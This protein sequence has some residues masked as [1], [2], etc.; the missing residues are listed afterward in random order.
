MRYVNPIA[1]KGGMLKI[2]TVGTF[3][4]FNPFSLKG[5]AAIGMGGLYKP[6]LI[7]ESL[8]TST[9]DD[10]L[11][12]YCYLAESVRHSIDNQWIIFNLRKDVFFHNGRLLTAK[13]VVFSF[14]FLKKKGSLFFKSHYRDIKKAVIL[15]E[16]CV[17]FLF[18]DAQNIHLAYI[19]GKLPVFCR[20]SD[21]Y[22]SS[23]K[24]K[25]NT[26]IGTGPYIVQKAQLGKY[27]TYRKNQN[28]WGKDHFFNRGCWNFDYITWIY[29]KDNTTCLEAFLNNEL[30]FR[31]ELRPFNW[32][33]KYQPQTIKNTIIQETFFHQ[34]S[35]GW[36]GLYFN[37]RKE[38]FKK[39]EVRKA[40]TYLFDFELI[41]KNYLFND[42]KRIKSVYEN[43]SLAA[44]KKLSLQE[45][46]ILT[47]L[48]QQFKNFVPCDKEIQKFSLPITDGSGNNRAH[49]QI[50]INYLK[51]AGYIYQKG[52][53]VHTS[54]SSALIFDI[55]IQDIDQQ[56]LLAPFIQ[57]LQSIGI[58]AQF[59]YVEN[60]Q[61][62]HYMQNFD[63]D[64]VVFA[65]SSSYTIG[66]E[67][68]NQW[69]SKYA[70]QKNSQNIAGVEN[71]AID[72]II[73]KMM[74]TPHHQARLSYAH[75]LDRLLKMGYYAIP[76]Y[77]NT[78]MWVAHHCS[79]KHPVHSPALGLPV[80]AT[81]WVDSSYKCK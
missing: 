4:H 74:Q 14:N 36:F 40:L 34:F 42:Y 72:A 53:L 57:T 81:W 76:L 50:A 43:T 73:E 20:F 58:E 9:Y 3:D 56:R 44:P 19:I 33:K 60:H 66:Q 17:K 45:K 78:Q 39:I 2:G 30:N 54:S 27:I 59:K 71:P 75:L 79:L 8:M 52:R 63:F 38:K 21:Q 23:F 48:R 22:S 65:P 62:N 47:K 16:H 25:Y 1:P 46:N 5:Q 67:Q 51:K 31:H 41:N 12:L 6:A 55:L 11:S 49:K 69:A 32:Y 61:Y 10:P 29:Y 24:V 26:F 68:K 15:N 35:P 80:H 70:H 28:F 18:S 37:T 13:D 64:M 77:Y 7:Y